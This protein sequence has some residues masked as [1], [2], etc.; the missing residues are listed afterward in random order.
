MGIHFFT[1]ASMTAL[2][3]PRLEQGVA[4]LDARALLLQ[5]LDESVL[6]RASRKKP[7]RKGVKLE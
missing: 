2:V 5:A 7:P 4:S 6:Q 1:F 3:V